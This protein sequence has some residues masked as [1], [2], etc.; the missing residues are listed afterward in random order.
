MAATVL[1]LAPGDHASNSRYREATLIHLFENCR[2]A[3]ADPRRQHGIDYLRGLAVLCIVIHHYH[4]LPYGYLAVDL[5]FAISGF[6]VG[7]ALIEQLLAGSPLTNTR[8]YLKR[9]TKILPS[10]FAFIAIAGVMSFVLYRVAQPDAVLRIENL[11][12][13]LFFYLNYR[14]QDSLIFAHI[15]SLCVEEHFYLLLPIAFLIIRRLKIR[16]ASVLTLLL[17]AGV[18]AINLL[19]ARLAAT[20]HETIV[21]THSRI[22]AMMWGM[23]AWLALRNRILL[24]SW[25]IG[26][27]F[28]A[29]ALL[30][31]VIS[32]DLYLQSS[33]FSAAIFHG[34]ISIVFFLTLVSVAQLRINHLGWLRFIS[35]F[36]YNYYLWHMR[37]YYVILKQFGE[38][39]LGLFAFIATGFIFAVFA[40]FL[41]EE[42]GLNLRSKFSGTANADPAIKL[43]GKTL[44]SA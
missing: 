35:Y 28:L 38:T 16:S 13:Y 17:I 26:L 8:F 27:L 6:L 10:Y 33:F 3:L 12:K 11:S 18:V 22:D 41:F 36:S 44:E 15:W 19:R 4:F 42:P 43:V 5:F 34:L 23:L 32:T 40:N 20:G 29:T 31:L 9:A 24:R 25:K 14:K 21:T 2:L 1:K 39:W 37:L 7:G 30:A